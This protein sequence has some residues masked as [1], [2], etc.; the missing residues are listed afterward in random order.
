[1]GLFQNIFYGAFE[2]PLLLNAQK[3]NSKC[4][5]GRQVRAPHAEKRPKTRLK[6]M[7]GKDDRNLFFSTFSAISF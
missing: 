1:M 2:T 5:R 3:F 7:M 4:K 6:K